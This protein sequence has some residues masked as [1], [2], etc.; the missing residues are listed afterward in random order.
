MVNKHDHRD[1]TAP[2]R[3]PYVLNRLYHGQGL[4]LREVAS[5][6]GCDSRTVRTWM[7]RHEIPTRSKSEAIGSNVGIFYTDGDGYERYSDGSTI[8]RIHRL[9]AVAGGASPHD[10]FGK[11]YHTH[12]VNGVKW[13]NRPENI[14]VHDPC[15]H[16]RLHA[17]LDSNWES[18]ECVWRDKDWLIEMYHGRRLSQTAIAREI[19]VT[20]D[21]ISRWMDKYEI[22]Q[23]PMSELISEGKLKGGGQ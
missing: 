14:E 7:S 17:E 4:S 11:G 23:R 18:D 13:D 8:V 1:P 15:E 2:H 3:D 19:G 16:R 22:E 6:L 21:T 20:P 5:R 12:H 9:L 10:V